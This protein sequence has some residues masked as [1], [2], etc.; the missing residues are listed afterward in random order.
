MTYCRTCAKKKIM[1]IVP[2]PHVDFKPPKL[3]DTG[4]CWYVYYS[5]KNPETG[6]FKRYRVKVN[7]GTIREKKAAARG[8]YGL[9]VAET[10][11]GWN[12]VAGGQG[13]KG[14][15]PAFEVFQAFENVKAKEMEAQSLASYRL[16]Y[17][18][19]P[20]VPGERRLLCPFPHHIHRPRGGQG[21]HGA[22]GGRRQNLPG[23]L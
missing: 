20:E 21:F 18:D 14:A 19:L 7:R 12:P 22:S 11:L 13:N 6:K 1:Y 5:V 2:R 8:D 15:V 10:C 16:L 23:H 17:P 3:H 4:D 9:A